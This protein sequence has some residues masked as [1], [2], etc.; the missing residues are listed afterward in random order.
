M[1]KTDTKT[2]EQT[3]HETNKFVRKSLAFA[4]YVFT[5]RLQFHAEEFEEAANTINVL[6]AMCEDLQ[7]K[8]E[9]VEPPAKK[10][11]TKETKPYVIDAGTIKAQDAVEATH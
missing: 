6:K 11:E 3:Q 8:I 5:Q 7:T 2:K 4:H 10:E 1:S 9:A